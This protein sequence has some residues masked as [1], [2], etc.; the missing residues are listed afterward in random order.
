MIGFPTG[1]LLSEE[2]SHGYLKRSLHPEGL[3]CRKTRSARS[4]GPARPPL[5]TD[6]RLP[7]PG[8]RGDLQRSSSVSPD[9][10]RSKTHYDPWATRDASSRICKGGSSGA[11]DRRDGSGL[12]VGAEAPSSHPGSS[13]AGGACRAPR[14]G[15]TRWA[16]RWNAR[17]W[18]VGSRGRSRR[19]VS[20][21]NFCGC[22]GKSDPH[23]D[24][25][26][27]PRQR[28][29]KAV[30]AQHVVELSVLMMS[31]LAHQSIQSDDQR[32]P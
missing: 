4:A 7:L 32:D 3:S 23:R 5:G 1:V 15:A 14:R 29:N 27:P 9:T 19:D 6:H 21:R 25:D 8:V 26:D 20:R 11:P 17:R 24:P 16:T 30:A 28:A 2:E 10:V 22:G 31:L 12:P 18:P 13:P